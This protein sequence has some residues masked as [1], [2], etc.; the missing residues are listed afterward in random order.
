MQVAVY[1]GGRYSLL[2]TQVRWSMLSVLL[3]VGI[4]ALHFG[5]VFAGGGAR[6]VEAAEW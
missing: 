3:F 4:A 1:R 2:A 5:V 6:D